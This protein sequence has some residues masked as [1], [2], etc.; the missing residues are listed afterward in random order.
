MPR[1]ISLY[2]QEIYGLEFTF[3]AFHKRLSCE[4]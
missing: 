3:V 4:M 2:L 1:K